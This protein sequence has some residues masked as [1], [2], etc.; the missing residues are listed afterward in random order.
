MKGFVFWVV[1]VLLFFRM[2]I[3][4]DSSGTKGIFLS[5]MKCTPLLDEMDEEPDSLFLR[6]RSRDQW[7]TLVLQRKTW[8]QIKT[9]RG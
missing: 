2:N 9:E 3:E 8:Q 7:I 1:D 6:R 5:Y 4:T